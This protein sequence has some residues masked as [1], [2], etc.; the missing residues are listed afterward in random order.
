MFGRREFMF[1]A[2]LAAASSLAAV[3]APPRVNL[4][5][6]V[7][8]VNSLDDLTGGNQNLSSP[9]KHFSS[10]HNYYIYGGGRPLHGLIVTIDLTEDLVAP[11]GISLQLNG[12][13]PT[14]DS[15]S[16]YQQYVTG[17]SPTNPPYLRGTGKPTPS[18][19]LIGWSM[20]NW[21]SEEYR[22][23]LHTTIGLHQKGDLFNKLGVIGVYPPAKDRIPAG[24][25]IKYQLLTDKNDPSGKIIGAI[26]SVKDDKGKETSSGPQLIKD[27][28][29]DG[30]D[31]PVSQESMSPIVALQMNLCGLNGGRFMFMKSGGGTITYEADAPLTAEGKVPTTVADLKTFTKETSNIVYGRVAAGPSSKIVQKFSAAPGS[32]VVHDGG[33]FSNS[34]TRPKAGRVQVTGGNSGN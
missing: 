22:R 5:H 14:G 4:G 30:V 13:A 24:Y 21:P 31:K 11:T 15:K 2:G 12:Y 6:P 23:H 32:H 29:F 3:A 33:T 26:Y 27:F 1:G 9:P 16:I 10:N 25:Q 17:I 7:Q 8:G 28:T 34:A 20:E 19:L 18:S